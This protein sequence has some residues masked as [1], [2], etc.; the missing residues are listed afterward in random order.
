MQVPAGD[1]FGAT[2]LAGIQKRFARLERHTGCRRLGIIRCT[3]EGW[4]VHENNRLLVI[5]GS[6][7]LLEEGELFGLFSPA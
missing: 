6:K 7:A 5:T 3:L 1:D 4:H 2:E